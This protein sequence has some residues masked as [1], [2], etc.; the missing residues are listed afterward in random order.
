M[1]SQE[2]VEVLF[3]GANVDT[4]AAASR[5]WKGTCEFGD[6]WCPLVSYFESTNICVFPKMAVPNNHGFSD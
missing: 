5:L 4:G 6:V 3:T 1:R 2:A